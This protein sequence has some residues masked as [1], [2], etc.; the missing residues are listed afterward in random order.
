MKKKLFFK[1][2][3]FAVIGSLVTMT[4]C[5]DYDDDIDVLQGDVSD[6]ST[7][8]ETMKSAQDALAAQVTTLQTA[9]QNA[10]DA[11]A[12]QNAQA[13]LDKANQALAQVTQI[14]ADITAL[15]TGKVSTADFNT[16]LAAVNKRIDD[17][18]P[19]LN[20]LIGQV[21]SLEFMP[22]NVVGVTPV[23][24]GFTLKNGSTNI[25]GTVT[26]KYQVNPKS[27]NFVNVV[28]LVKKSAKTR[29]SDVTVDI[30]VSA[31]NVTLADGVLTVKVK[32]TDFPAPATGTTDLYALVVDNSTEG[33]ESR[34]VY[35]D[36]VAAQINVLTTTPTVTASNIDVVYD[37][38]VPVYLTPT[39]TTIF[40]GSSLNLNK[41]GFEMGYEFTL[42][43]TGKDNFT[44]DP[45]TGLVTVNGGYAA[46]NT[47][48]NVAIKLTKVN[49]VTLSNSI[50]GPT[51][52]VKA[53]ASAPTSGN[54]GSVTKEFT[55]GS[56]ASFSEKVFDIADFA[57][58][59]SRPT[60]DFTG[61]ST[62]SIF[63]ENGDLLTTGITGPINLSISGN[64]VKINVNPD[65]TGQMLDLDKVY[66]LKRTY[67]FDNG[68]VT[69][70]ATVNVKV[71]TPTF[72]S[73]RID[74]YWE[75]NLLKTKG[76]IIN[77]AWQM[78]TDL[79]NAYKTGTI[80]IVGST[81]S[82]F[83][84]ADMTFA[85]NPDDANVSLPS[86]T[87][88]LTTTDPAKIQQYMEGKKVNVDVKVAKNNRTFKLESIQ[89][90]FVSP[91]TITVTP[92]S[93]KASDGNPDKIWSQAITIN[94]IG[95]STDSNL[96]TTT[97]GTTTTYSLN[98]AFLTKYSINIPDVATGNPN[99]TLKFKNGTS[100]ITD[101]KWVTYNNTIPLANDLTGTY[102][103]VVEYGPNG[104]YKQTV[105]LPVTV[106]K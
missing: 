75:G 73:Y 68:R 13:A 80:K 54:L 41:E 11:T 34:Y 72:E 28:G 48:A 61:N 82:I 58:I 4:S 42:S 50:S 23:I 74:A 22:D 89:V 19:T 30:P 78:S 105:Q 53:V 31:S 77:S 62:D 84:D 87:I 12:R 14:V 95:G 46:V 67:S 20:V 49:G 100:W 2:F 35:S 37:N 97:S 55:Y 10:T 27:A 7:K 86:S 88:S 44:I 1:L 9:V 70:V 104:L 5:K 3:I 38:S 63:K 101:N 45:A 52:T 17:I 71:T 66:T 33:A 16:A 40:G 18:T 92:V 64:D 90:Q 57:R 56:A 25:G 6:L 36:Y 59:S 51:I 32:S 29:A 81:T 85:K 69:Y 65:V 8:Y 99:L 83:S 39:V 96:T 15:Q 102:N 79:K 24:Y 98:S 94:G 21:T 26:L 43:G 103:V 60:T 106:L 76:S 47:T 93:F 91:L